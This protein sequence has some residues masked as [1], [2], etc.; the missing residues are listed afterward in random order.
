[1][2]KNFFIVKMVQK[3]KDKHLQ[4]NA[5]QGFPI[6]IGQWLPDLKIQVLIHSI[7][8]QGG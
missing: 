7:V 1:M 3:I 5:A 8:I 2:D 4:Q 6:I